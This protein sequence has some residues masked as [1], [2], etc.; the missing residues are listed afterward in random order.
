M[1]EFEAELDEFHSTLDV[2]KKSLEEEKHCNGSLQI[3]VGSLKEELAYRKEVQKEGKQRS[4]EVR[5]V[6]LKS[7]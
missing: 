7:T 4:E 6:T 1:K 3:S 5:N 2:M